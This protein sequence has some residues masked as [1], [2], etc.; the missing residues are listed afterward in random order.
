MKN[1]L[2]QKDK[3]I[4]E[5]LNRLE[6][7]NEKCL[8]V[9][10]RNNTLMG[11]LTDGDIRRAI[12]NGASVNSKIDQY[13]KKNPIFL[14]ETQIDKNNSNLRLNKHIKVLLK[15]INDDHIDI[16]PIVD[17]KLK[18]KKIIYKKNLKKYFENKKI[19][20]KIPVLIMA[21][22]RGE[23]LKQFTNYFPKPLVPVADSTALEYI[24]NLFKNFGVGKLFISLNYKKNLI[25]SYLKENKVRNLKFLE[26]NNMLGT[27]GPINLLKGKVKTDFFV[28]NCDSILSINLE[29]FYDYHKKNNYKIT[30]V[31]ASKSFKLSYGSCKI[32]KNGQLKKI[33]EK[34]NMNYLVNV[35]LYLLKPEIINLVPKNKL[36][37]MDFLIKKVKNSRGKVGV[38]PITE[39]NWYDTGQENQGRSYIDKS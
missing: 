8:L 17:R 38:F 6:K 16:I 27:A 14:K 39:E 5:A 34:P 13:I 25:K 31:A 10:R 29:K 7:N 37:D 35:G 2:L 20:E 9:I 36:F 30:L 19:L 24:I 3:T 23:R 22:G 4:K 1:Y 21:G 15:K 33:E 12:L 26:E 18:I 28:I 32:K 11:S